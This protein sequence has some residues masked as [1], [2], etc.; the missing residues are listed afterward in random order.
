[1]VTRHQQDERE[2]E[3][4]TRR[5]ADQKRRLAEAALERENEEHRFNMKIAIDKL[6]ESEIGRRIIELIGEEELYKYDPESLNS[7]HIDA[8][9]KDSREKKDK[10]KI[11]FKKV[12][13]L[14][15]ALHEAETA[16]IK[17]HSE[18]DVQRRRNI[19]LIERER[20][21][22]RSERLLRMENDKKD[23]LKSIRGQRHEDFVV[24]MKEFDQRFQVARQQRLEQ[25][26]KEHIEKK[27]QDWKTQK[28]V[29]TQR[30]ETE[31][32]Q[33]VQAELKRQQDERNASVRAA[34][35]AKNQKLAEQARKQRE[36]EDEIER[37]LQEQGQGQER[38]RDDPRNTSGPNRRP[39]APPPQQQKDKTNRFVYLYSQLLYLY[40]FIV[41]HGDVVHVKM[42]IINNHMLSRRILGVIEMTING[43]IINSVHFFHLQKV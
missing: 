5:D 18:D 33:K 16:V 1:M 14:I 42:T 8:V 7:L 10:L 22:E 31:K 11:Q 19:Q 30:K 29:D 34:D 3:D 41:N 25:L 21:M 28:Q 2:K 23:F 39:A 40:V 35:D 37:K 36:R 26:R 13:F 32:Q 6:R 15:R 24:Q 9:I 12:D 38:A 27:K 4:K 43:K 17:K 20:A